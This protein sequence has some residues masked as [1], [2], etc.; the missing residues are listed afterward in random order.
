MPTVQSLDDLIAR[1]AA[2]FADQI[3]AAAGLADKEEEIRIETEKQLAFIQKEAGIKLEGRHEFTVASGRVDSVYD[4]VIIEY[5]NPKSPADRI[6]PK[7]DSP[8]SRKVVEQIKKRFYDMRTQH[9]QPLNTLFGV[10]LDGNH[11]IFVRFRDDKWQVQ[12]PVEVNRYSA[13]RFLW[14]LFNLGNKGKPFSPEYLAG[15]FG[16]ESELARRGVCTLYN[17]I[18][19]TD[20][21]RAQTFFKQ[22]KILFGEVCGYDVDSPS[23]KIRKLAEFYGAPTQGVGAAPLLFAVHTYYSIFMKLLAAEIVA[24]FHKLPTPLQKMMSATTTAKLKR[25]VEDLE[26]GSL[27]RHL[28]ITNFLE[29]D[30]FAWYTSVWC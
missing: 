6:G 14:A 23:E 13:E 24:F 2:E 16:S 4:R 26:A 30:L 21:P 12:E 27:F 5:K 28:N 22:W 11:F 9:R 29:G 17:A 8:G 3:T 19:S 7:P 18:I 10:G 1:K 20:H 25:E 15:D